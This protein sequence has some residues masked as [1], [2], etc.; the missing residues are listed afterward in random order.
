MEYVRRKD[1]RKRSRNNKRLYRRGKLFVISG[2]SGVGKDTLVAEALKKI[3]NCKKIVTATTR[4]PRPGEKDQNG[5][6][7]LTG[8]E[9]ERMK[10]RDGFLETAEV[11]GYQ[12]GTPREAVERELEKENKVILAIDVQGARQIKEK[13]RGA[14]LIFIKPPSLKELRKRLDERSTEDSKAKDTRIETAGREISSASWY[15]H[16][17]VNRTV[18]QAANDL[19]DIIEA[20]T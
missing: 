17:I 10:I 20:G 14:V 15:D 18:K 13:M 4:R 8:D 9:F 7:F 19:A 16:V 5:Y 3:K 1:S 11:H 6:I 12:Y 2:P